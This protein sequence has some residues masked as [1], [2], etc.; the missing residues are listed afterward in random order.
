MVLTWLCLTGF[1]SLFWA[2]PFWVLPTLTMTSST[3]AVAI[4]FINMCANLAGARDRPS[5]G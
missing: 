2:T 4:G 3:A 5:W 1:F